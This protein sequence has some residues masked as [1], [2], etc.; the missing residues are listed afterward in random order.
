MKDDFLIKIETWHISDLGTQEN[1]STCHVFVPLF[2]VT[3]LLSVLDQRIAVWNGKMSLCPWF[4]MLIA[5]ARK[6][7]PP[8]GFSYT[9]NKIVPQILVLWGHLCFFRQSRVVCWPQ[10]TS[11]TRTSL[12]MEGERWL[13]ASP[14]GFYDLRL[15]VFCGWIRYL[16]LPFHC[17]FINWSQM[18]GRT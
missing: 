7:L 2:N 8:L 5:L 6:R 11:A 1:V 14:S 9:L 3:V 4:E 17:R 16:V 18:Y 13:S 12:Y 15:G 10:W